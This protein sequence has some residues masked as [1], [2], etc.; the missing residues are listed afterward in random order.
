MPV[1]TDDC[2]FPEECHLG[3]KESSNLTYMSVDLAEGGTVQRRALE[4]LRCRFKPQGY[5]HFVVAERRG[6]KYL[7][8]A[9]CAYAKQVQGILREVKTWKGQGRSWQ[10]AHKSDKSLGRMVPPPGSKSEI[11]AEGKLISD[12]PNLAPDCGV[13]NPCQR[14]GRMQVEW[15]VSGPK[16]RCDLVRWAIDKA[17]EGG[18]GVGRGGGG[19]GG[20]QGE[21]GAAGGEAVVGV[22]GVVGTLDR[23]PIWKVP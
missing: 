7:Y 8:A 5:R 18:G 13:A 10:E 1:C 23:T 4:H 21:G 9:S 15:S 20:G 6:K 16:K 17:G 12:N 19:G 3:E 2:G 11:F 22:A 14:C